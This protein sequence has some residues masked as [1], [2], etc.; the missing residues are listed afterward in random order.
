MKALLAKRQSL[1]NMTSNEQFCQII[2]KQ[3]LLRSTISDKSKSIY[4]FFSVV[5]ERLWVYDNWP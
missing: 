3:K 2:F 1:Q 5:K 4:Q